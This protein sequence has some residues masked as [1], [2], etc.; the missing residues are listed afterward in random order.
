MLD[1]LYNTI[2]F[3][4][5]YGCFRS[6]IVILQ[7]FLF[8][9]CAF[10]GWY[11]IEVED[12]YLDS[13]YLNY[14]IINF[15]FLPLTLFSH[16]Q[17]MTTEPGFIDSNLINPFYAQLCHLIYVLSRI[18]TVINNDNIEDNYNDKHLSDN[19]Y[20]IKENIYFLEKYFINSE[21]EFNSLNKSL[22]LIQD[23]SF[24]IKFRENTDNIDKILK[25]LSESFKLFFNNECS[26]CKN[27][28][29]EKTHHCSVCQK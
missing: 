23:S 11:L 4:S 25:N 7:Y 3:K 9:F 1:Q 27:F 21:K 2:N 24:K 17:C 12:K 20:K 19:L 22:S 14:F 18:E 6:F 29:Y 16:I 15:I 13:L 26:V 8:S 5:F 28:K 10:C